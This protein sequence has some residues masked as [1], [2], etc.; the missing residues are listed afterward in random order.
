MEDFRKALNYSFLLLKYRPRSRGEIEERLKRKKYTSSVI[1]KVLSHLEGYSYI[2]DEEFVPLFISSCIN[3]GWGR[4]KIDFALKK[5]KIS[6]SLRE[7]FLSS[8]SIDRG[9]LQQLIDRKLQFYKG[10]KNIYQK[11]V[12]F[13]VGRGF[14]YKDIF[15]ELKEVDISKFESK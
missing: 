3:K 11:I 4:R 9:K 1:I 12:R 5:L 2:N 13:L 10:K 6:R 15:R 8:R 14:E 7:R